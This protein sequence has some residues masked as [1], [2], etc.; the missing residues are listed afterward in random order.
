[1]V[2]SVFILVLTLSEIA[3]TSPL[4]A[5]DTTKEEE[6]RK[7]DAVLVREIIDRKRSTLER[8]IKLAVILLCSRTLLDSSAL[9]HRLSLLRR[10]SSLD[11][12][13]SLFLISPVPIAEVANFVQSL[14]SELM[15]S[16]MDFYREHGRRVRRKRARL[17]GSLVANGGKGRLG[18]KGWGVRYDFK[19]GLFAEMRG[20]VEVALK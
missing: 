16:S 12:R 2:P 1:M 5:N 11:T 18:E 17:S 20:E 13:A 4:D 9:D 19:L 8:G 14:K 10:Q 6:E 3:P 7:A 15:G